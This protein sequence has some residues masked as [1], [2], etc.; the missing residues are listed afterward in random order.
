MTILDLLAKMI[1]PVGGLVRVLEAAKLQAPDLAPQIDEWLAKLG[2]AASQS[3]LVTLAK[4][5]PEEI[6]AIAGGKIDPRSHP[7]DAA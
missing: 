3:N 2:A 5:L 4:V 1:G 6:A 7:S